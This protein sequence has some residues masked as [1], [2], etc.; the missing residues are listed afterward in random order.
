LNNRKLQILGR[1]DDQVKLRGYRI[2]LDEVANA[3]MRHQSVKLASAVVI[4]KT[5]VAYVSPKNVDE[6]DLKQSLESILP[7]YMLPSL[8]VFM[9]ELPV[10]VNGKVDRKKL[11]TMPLEVAKAGEDILTMSDAQTRLALI[12]A[13]ILNTSERIGPKSSF[14]ALGG[15]SL[16]VVKM[17]AMANER[18]FSFTVGEVFKTPILEL[19]ARDQTLQV[20]SRFSHRPSRMSLRSMAPQKRPIILCLHG[21]GTSAEIFDIQLADVQ[22]ALPEVEFVCINAPYQTNKSD[23]A[24]VF[25]GPYFKWWEKES[26]LSR[27]TN[28]NTKAINYVVSQINHILENGDRMI[29]GLLGFSEGAEMVH[30]MD[31]LQAKGVL[32]RQWKFSVLMSCGK[33]GWGLFNMQK[34]NVPSLHVSGSDSEKRV[35]AAIQAKYSGYIDTLKHNKGHLIPRNHHFTSEFVL[36][37]RKLMLHVV[38][39]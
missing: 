11:K 30:L 29:E 39:K 17:T 21:F 19:L 26:V 37:I 13:S 27:Y 34:L 10:N 6:T 2:E 24:D 36:K 22:R 31:I 20:P 9:D 12:W 5:L 38:N 33:L 32:K 1:A 25:E 28:Q 3:L 16:S 35:S 4:D 15:D 14:F 7:H 23:V 18:G 8:Y